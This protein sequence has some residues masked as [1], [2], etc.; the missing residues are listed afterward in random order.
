MLRASRELFQRRLTEVLKQCGV[1]EPA[2]LAAFGQEVGEAH[3]QLAAVSGA[4]EGTDQAVALTVSR[5][6]LMSDD[7]LELDIRMAVASATACARPAV[8]TCGEAS[9]AI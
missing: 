5:L 4:R 8:V 2:V 6:T 7:E 3:D 9:C 1:S